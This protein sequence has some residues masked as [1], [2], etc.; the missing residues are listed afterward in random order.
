MTNYTRGRRFE[1]RVRDDLKAKGFPIVVLMPQSRGLFDVL[2]IGEA[3]PVPEIRLIQCKITPSL[4]GG[5]KRMELSALAGKA[6]ASAYL[7]YR[8]PKPKC[9]IIYEEL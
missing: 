3:F 5:K 6:G 2:A 4:L 8:G 9:E 7:A 1:Y